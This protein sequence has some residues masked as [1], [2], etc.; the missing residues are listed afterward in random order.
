MTRVLRSGVLTVVVAVAISVGSATAAETVR[1]KPAK[2]TEVILKPN[3]AALAVKVSLSELSAMTEMRGQLYGAGKG[4]LAVLQEDGKVARSVPIQVRQVA[5]LAPY[6]D[7]RLLIGDARNNA[8]LTLNPETGKT[9]KLLALSEVSKG[10]VPVSVPSLLRGARL[11]SVAFDGKNV[12]AATRAGYSSSIFKIDP[13]KKRL[14]AHAWAPGPDPIAMQF[15]GDSLFVLDGDNQQVRRFDRAMKLNLNAVAIPVD[16]ARGFVIKGQQIKVL[17][18]D[19]TIKKA[20]INIAKL[21]VDKVM[22]ARPILKISDLVVMLAPQ[23]Y[24]VLICGDVAESGFDEFWNDTV[25]LYK[26]L[27]NA[28]YSKD[29]IYVLYGDGADF[30]SANPSYQYGETVTDFPARISWVNTVFDGLKNGDTA[31]GIKKMKSNDTL[32]IWTFDHGTGGSPAYLC[33]RDG[34]MTDSS[35]AA[36]ANVVPFAKRAVFMQQCRSGGF[37]DDLRNSKTFISTACRH[38]QNAQRADTENESYGGSWYHH[39]EYN[40]HIISSLAGATPTGAGINADSNSNG[41]VSARESHDWN[42]S[43]ESRAEVPQMDDGAG[44]GSS[45]HIQ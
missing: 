5:G 26:T 34:N 27:R 14:L 10:R 4:K 8:L 28:G 7:N 39:G 3:R 23:K 11:A 19:R 36:K 24:A 29:N 44:I 31:N 35:F 17:S 45:F 12:Y 43:H 22:V 20:T 30:A 38:N 42:V 37:I 6:R 25:W 9:A 18:S 40:Y 33:L 41:S 2:R 32:F 1:A 13:V 15:V 16:R 21:R